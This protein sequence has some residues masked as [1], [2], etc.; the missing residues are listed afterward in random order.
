MTQA[1][2]RTTASTSA[3]TTWQ[4]WVPCLGMALCSWLSF[5]DRQVLNILAPTI[6]K[7]TALGSEAFQIRAFARRKPGMVGPGRGVRVALWGAD[8]SS[9]ELGELEDF[10]TYAV[11]QAEYF[12]DGTEGEGGWMWN[13]KWRGRLKRF[14]LPEDSTERMAFVGLCSAGDD[15][16]SPGGAFRFFAKIAEI[17]DLVMH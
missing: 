15:Q 7:D 2:V 16:E 6:I 12:Y 4:M 3:V 11:A 10:G 14:R 17:K 5:V 1:T 8:E 9:S 13:M